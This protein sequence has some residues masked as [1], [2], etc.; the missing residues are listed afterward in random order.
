MS[1]QVITNIIVLPL[2]NLYG[3]SWTAVVNYFRDIIGEPDYIDEDD[4]GEVFFARYEGDYDI[5]KEGN[6][7]G[8][9]RVITKECHDNEF[10]DLIIDIETINILSQDLAD[11]FDGKKSDCKIAFLNWYNGVERPKVLG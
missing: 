5:I 9:E 11:R 1:N 2:P 4:G 3:K 8:V 7:W 6:K 10:E